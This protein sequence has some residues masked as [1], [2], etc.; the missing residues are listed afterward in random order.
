M[1]TNEIKASEDVLKGHTGRKKRSVAL[2]IPLLVLSMIVLSTGVTFAHCDTM[3]GPVI[4][5]A[6]T[7]IDKDNV[8]YV[9][10]WIQPQDEKELKETFLLTMNVRKLSSDAL[11]LADRYFFET[12]VRLHRSGE[13]VPYTGLKPSGIPLDEKVLAA[14]RS[15]E[16][17]DLSR[18]N[19]L[20]PEADL[21][22]LKKRFERA[23]SLKNFEVDNVE[24][25]RAYVEAYVQFF[26]FAEGEES[27]AAESADPHSVHNH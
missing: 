24:A 5:D 19:K 9:L 14:D 15:I 23:F 7:A 11:L 22:E 20:V 2:M 6:R 26:K 21:P 12:L 13:G 1:K 4:K 8:N 3:D 18:L 25:G 17:G 27:H 16:T 10:K